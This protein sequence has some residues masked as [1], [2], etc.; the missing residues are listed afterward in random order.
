MNR[1]IDKHTSWQPANLLGK[2]HPSRMDPGFPATRLRRGRKSAWSRNLVRENAVTVSDLIWPLFVIEGNQARQPVASMP[3]VERLSIDLAVRAAEAAAKLE[4]P[5]IALF[6]SVEPSLRSPDGRE[7]LN[8][9]NLICRAIKAIKQSVPDI[10]ILCDVALDPYTSHGHDGLMDGQ[11]IT[12]DRTIDVLC[13]QSLI[14]AEAGCDIIAPS[15]MMDGRVAGIRQTLEGNGFE[16]VM[17]MAYSA[18]FASSFY[19]PFRDAIGSSSALV[20]DKKTYQMDPGNS[21]EAMREVEL[22][23]AEGADM[24]LVKPGLPYLDV[25]FRVKRT[26]AVPTFVYQVSGEYA[27][28]RAAARNGWL[29]GDKIT[30]ESLLA[31]KRAGADG[32][33][34]YFACEV[35]SRIKTAR[36]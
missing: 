24:V 36:A 25:L 1:N 3:G 2:E 8:P 22:D 33:L 34:T 26:F 18:K 16:S 32:I 4:I 10:G 30:D 20:G 27:M 17:I 19:G 6:P 13:R 14:Q 35:A 31:F 21:D 28:I 11:E 9:D 5:V 29:D 7:A 23:L 15:D 12:N